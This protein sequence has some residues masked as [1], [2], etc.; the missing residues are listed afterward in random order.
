MQRYLSAKSRGLLVSKKDDL[1]E[2]CN[3]DNDLD[4]TNGPEYT[5]EEALEKGFATTGDYIFSQAIT[6]QTLQEQ[7][8]YALELIC[9]TYEGYV[10][11]KVIEL[12]GGLYY[13]S[14]I[15]MN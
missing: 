2:F 11:P 9:E 7:I 6:K 13:A 4:G 1:K 10:D 3:F 8:Q 12:P 14:I 5:S 15:V